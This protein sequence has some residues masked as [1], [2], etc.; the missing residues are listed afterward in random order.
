M[1]EKQVNTYAQWKKELVGYVDLSLPFDQYSKRFG[2][3][4]SDIDFA[5]RYSVAT[6]AATTKNEDRE[7]LPTNRKLSY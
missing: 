2:V 7:E 6:T 5:A 1:S 3:R 4:Q